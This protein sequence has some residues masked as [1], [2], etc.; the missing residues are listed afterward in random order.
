MFFLQIRFTFTAQVS[1]H[2]HHE[3]SSVGI[4]EKLE[5][6]IAVGPGHG[7]QESLACY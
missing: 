6:L 7:N 1:P 2:G 5:H 4:S 3:N